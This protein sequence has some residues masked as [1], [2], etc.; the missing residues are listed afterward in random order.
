[1]FVEF[2]HVGTPPPALGRDRLHSAGGGQAAIRPERLLRGPRV[3]FIVLVAM[4][5]VVGF[6]TVT[7]LP[8]ALVR[9]F[10]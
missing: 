1:V 4:D 3:G 5:L 8:A 6:P 2:Q 10:G 7:G 9:L